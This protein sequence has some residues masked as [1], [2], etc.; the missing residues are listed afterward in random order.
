LSPVRYELS[1]YIPEDDILH[2]HRRE[3]LK[4]Y[5]ALT[6]WTLYRRR[7][8]SPVRYELS[9][10]IPEDDI[11]HSHRRQN[12]KSYIVIFMIKFQLP[13]GGSYFPHRGSIPGP[14]EHPS[15]AGTIPALQAER[16]AE[17]LLNVAENTSLSRVLHEQI[18]SKATGECL[19]TLRVSSSNSRS[20][21]V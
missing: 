7:N 1:Y 10:Y 14:V 2:S 8:V 15:T 3:K 11:L 16:M 17:P 9:F 18:A 5:I 20:S 21:F 6:G 19:L 4:S 12:L 13:D